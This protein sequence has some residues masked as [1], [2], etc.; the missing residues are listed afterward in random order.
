MRAT[1][2]RTTQQESRW[3]HSLTE[4]GAQSI[5]LDLPHVP[6]SIIATN[7]DRNLANKRLTPHDFAR[8]LRFEILVSE[9]VGS[10]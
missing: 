8:L 10:N 1:G 2:E 4:I 3:R 5:C 6:A 9:R 7:H